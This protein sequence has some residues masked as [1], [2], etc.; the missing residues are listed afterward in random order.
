MRRYFGVLISVCFLMSLAPWAS[1]AQAPAPV[2]PVQLVKIFPNKVRY[3]RGEQG[4]VQVVLH[5]TTATEQAVTLEG[6]ITQ[7]LALVTPLPQR[8]VTVPA[9]ND[10][11]I[12]LPFTAPARD[13]GCAVSVRVMQDD[14]EIARAL[15]MCNVAENVWNVA[16]GASLNIGS[17][18]GYAWQTP[19]GLQNDLKK[20]RANYFNWWE[21][22]FW[23]PDDW[24]DLT[25]KE[26]KW[27][28][29]E[30]GRL[31]VKSTIKNFITLAKANGIASVTYGKCVSGGPAGWEI[32][33][34]HP[35]WFLQNPYGQPSGGTYNTAYFPRAKWNSIQ[36]NAGGLS[37][38]FYLYPRLT[39]LAA[40]DWGI[41]Q[42]ILSAQEYGWDGVRF[43]GDFTANSGSDEGAARN[44]RR[45]KERIWAK[46]PNYVFGFNEGYGPPSSDPSTWNH[47][48]RETL[49]GGGHWMNEGISFDGPGKWAISPNNF[50]ISYEEY[51]RKMNQE[52]DSLRKAGASYHII[53]GVPDNIRGAYKF[54]LATQA[55]AHPVYGS[56]AEVAGCANWG[57]FLT[58]WSAFVWD[59]NLRNRPDADAEIRSAVPLWHAVKERVVDGETKTTVVHLIVPPT[60]NEIAAEGVQVGAPAQQVEVR[61]RIPVNERV[62]RTMVIATE[63]P[64]T[65]LEITST[66]EDEW[67]T[68]VVPEVKG[69]SIVVFECAGTFTSP[70]YPK[71]TEPP[72]AEK[73]KEGEANASTAL[74]NDPL[75]PGKEAENPDKRSISVAHTY[76]VK[77]SEQVKDPEA[78]GGVCYRIASGGQGGIAHAV[79]QDLALG[80]YRVTARMKLLPD[81]DGDPK[82]GY[83]GFYI[84]LAGS[85]YCELRGNDYQLK[86]NWHASDF[87][88]PGKYEDFSGE[89]DFLGDGNQIV[90]ILGWMGISGVICVDTISIEK[91]NSYSDAEVVK[92]LEEMVAKTEKSYEAQAANAEKSGQPFKRWTASK[93]P[94]LSSPANVELKKQGGGLNILVVNGL[95]F[96]LYRIPEALTALGKVL[97]ATPELKLAEG[98]AE[99]RKESDPL[100]APVKAN[101]D[102]GEVRVNYVAMDVTEVNTTLSG[103]PETFADLCNYD[104]VVLLNVSASCLSL[105]E[106]I[107]LRDFVKAGGGLL[108][109]GGN[110]TLGQGQLK[111]TFLEDM[112]PVTLAT[113]EAKDVRQA[114]KPL[115]LSKP[116]NS[117]AHLLSGVVWKEPAYLY[118]RHIVKPKPEAGVELLAGG[119]PV[120][121]SGVFGKGR[122]VVFTGTVLGELAAKEQPFWQSD[123]W[124]RVMQNTITWLAHTEMP[125]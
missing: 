47:G 98:I 125:K 61:A 68:A 31:E 113:A 110:F 75:K 44:Q 45:M 33:R 111:G 15:D 106:R 11:A 58:R 59:I 80:R 72:N 124:I 89:F 81:K 109:L 82:A 93:K 88:T 20:S 94:E 41:D 49:A 92:M 102:A 13:Y 108:V 86:P 48:L 66:R 70:T 112:L 77:E 100:P 30:G 84:P 10:L 63:H 1:L 29:G 74:S 21:K 28:S 38:W 34:R 54:L 3:Q 5:N 105:P 121:F 6:D 103:Y 14:K 9:N 23:A 95:Y 19:E 96:D 67:V 69:W 50:Y 120:L 46:L 52:A 71:F 24:G 107:R 104:A 85:A 51:W 116:A 56:S 115:Q 117:P 7:E 32:A 57:R 22:M 26:E 35:D 65:A 40:L 101:A 27:R 8:K 114:A 83:G 90:P 64:D 79:F 12:D 60:L 119:E 18:S 76:G 118:W 36:G 78:A 16:L 39:S 4:T 73:V 17:S 55:G 123:G 91:I 42:L 37:Q 43:D 62:V 2:N 87:K 53:Y 25:P 122:V 97:D 99:P